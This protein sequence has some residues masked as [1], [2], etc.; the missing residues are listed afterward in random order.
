MIEDKSIV[1]VLHHVHVF[2]KEEL[3]DV[4]FAVDESEEIFELDG[5]GAGRYS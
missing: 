1:F 3:D 2:F 4:E 5:D